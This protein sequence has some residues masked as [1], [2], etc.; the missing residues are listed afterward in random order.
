MHRR[1]RRADADMV[2]CFAV[3]RFKHLH[4]WQKSRMF[5]ATIDGELGQSGF[6]DGLGLNSDRRRL[7]SAVFGQHEFR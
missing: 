3:L 6:G 2:E 7:S 5:A 4:I 1:D